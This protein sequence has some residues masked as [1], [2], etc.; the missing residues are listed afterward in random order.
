MSN[1]WLLLGLFL[2]RNVLHARAMS[3]VQ[4]VDAAAAVGDMTARG[5][6]VTF[7]I[8]IRSL[9]AVF[10]SASDLMWY[11][12]RPAAV[13]LVRSLLAFED[14]FSL[15]ACLVSTVTIFVVHRQLVVRQLG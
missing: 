2:S 3:R 7:V 14:G 11:D 8:A 9:A 12:S 10:F 4:L 1:V 6:A 15:A 13:F 5:D